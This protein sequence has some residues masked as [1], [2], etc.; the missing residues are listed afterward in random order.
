MARK[1][2]EQGAPVDDQLAEV[3]RSEL[4]RGAEA[5]AARIRRVLELLAE[6]DMERQIIPL[7]S[8]LLAHPDPYVRSKAT[9]MLGHATKSAASVS[10]RS[11][12]P[13]ARV[14][15]NAVE[16]MWGVDTPEA[17]ELLES[18]MKSRNHRAVANALVGFYRLHEVSSI[19]KLHAMAEH[20]EEPFRVSARWA[21]GETGDPRFIPFLKAA[22][23]ADTGKCRGMVVRSLA[24]LRRRLASLES[25]GVLAVDVRDRRV[26]PDGRRR[27]GISLL[28]ASRDA[29]I[30]IGPMDVVITSGS[31]QVTDYSIVGLTEPD[32]VVAGFAVPRITSQTDPYRTAI[33]QGFELCAEVKH[34]K[35]LWSIDRYRIGVPTEGEIDDLANVRDDPVLRNHLRA[36]RGFLTDTPIILKVASTLGTRD[37]ASHDMRASAKKLIDAVVRA[38][39]THHIFLFPDPEEPD[40]EAP[41]SAVLKAAT[42]AE[43]AIHCI[44][45]ERPAGYP[46][47]DALCRATGGIFDAESAANVPGTFKKRY[48]SLRNRYE[49]TVGGTTDPQME[50]TIYSSAGWNTVPVTFA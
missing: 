28:S 4:G 49:I 34:A 36:N 35:D 14:Q 17:R 42:E 41:A 11:L 40:P 27:V 6:L 50:I 26:L 29:H 22:F 38:A 44:A 23:Q 21:M 39:G 33:Q 7:R 31:K 2:L 13:D 32:R 48:Q 37:Q 1:A 9:L 24:R 20:P 18:A 3:L 16:S 47:L 12:D 45:L 19:E 43:V 25:A 15:A 8:P 30:A 46:G 10:K 5:Q